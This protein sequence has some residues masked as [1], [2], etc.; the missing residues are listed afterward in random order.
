MLSIAWQGDRAVTQPWGATSVL[1]EPW[2]QATQTHWHC[3][4]DIAFNTGEPIYAARAGIV[5]Y[6][7]VGFLAVHVNSDTDWYLHGSSYV[8]AP[9]QVLA[10]GQL[11][12]YAGNVAPPGGSSSGSHLHFEVQSTQ[13]PYCNTPSTSLDP[14]PVLTALYSGAGGS[15]SGGFGTLTDIEIQARFVAVLDAV[16]GVRTAVNAVDGGMY[17][18]ETDPTYGTYSALFNRRLEAAVVKAGGGT[19]SAAQAQEL[20]Q[21]HDNVAALLAARQSDQAAVLAAIAQL[22]SSPVV[23]TDPVLLAAVQAISKHVGV[24]TA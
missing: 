23:T 17:Y 19:L 5:A 21:A 16:A 20:Q 1:A 12:G 11:V 8:V 13:A 14:V 7:G 15:I 2:W 18:P 22:G 6:V 3:G 4:I 9:G 24:G 10:P